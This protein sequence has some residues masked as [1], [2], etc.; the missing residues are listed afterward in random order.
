MAAGSNDGC[1]DEFVRAL[2]DPSAPPPS[3]L[4]GA[5]GAQSLKRFNVYRN[6]VVVS[7]V[8]ALGQAFPALKKLV[9]TARFDQ[10]AAVYARARPPR[11]PVMLAYGDDF[12]SW[13]ETEFEPARA[14]A[15]LPDLARLELARR[16]AYHAADAAPLDAA[17]FQAAIA[18]A[19][20][21]Q[22]SGARL[23]THPSLR[24]IRSE[25]P[26]LTLWS[27]LQAAD[28]PEKLLWK[29]SPA[30]E[31]AMALRP[32]LE[33][34]MRGVSPGVAAFLEAAADGGAIAEIAVAGAQADNAF[35]MSQALG[36]ALADGVFTRVLLGV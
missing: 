29:V 25:W 27:D 14:F 13:L 5:N 18:G 28:A 16:Q 7:L 26:V 20:P 15:F 3:D 30:P 12:P 24:V 6:N 32:A 8:S 4:I 31:R 23:Q 35:D 11:S 1:Q 22:I 2:L 19:T 9:G 17:G 36:G 33:L 21:E 34:F 10:M